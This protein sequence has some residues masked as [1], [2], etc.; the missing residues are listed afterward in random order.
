MSDVSGV[1]LGDARLAAKIQLLDARRHG[2]HLAIIP[3]LTVPTGSADAF[4]GDRGPVFSPALVG[5]RALGA[6]R[7]S[8]NAGYRVR[9][10]VTAMNLNVADELFMRV[11]AG[12]RFADAGGPPLG[13][14]LSVTGATAA[15]DPLA[16]FN[17]N[18]L[19]LL[20]GGTYQFTR[21]VSGLAG[22][23]M[24][25]EEGFGA[26]DWRVLIGLRIGQR[27]D[28]V[29]DGPAPIAMDTDGDGIVDN[30]D[31]CP[32]V[33]EDL[34]GFEDTDGCP[35]ADNDGDGVLDTADA[36]PNTAGVIENRGCPDADRDGDTV[37]DRLDN[38][39]DEPG[40]RENF[41]CAEAQLVQ[42][43]ADRI[44]ILD[45]VYFETDR[46]EIRRRSYGLLRNVA[47]V[48]RAHPEI[49]QIQVEG[50]TDSR[51]T[52][53]YNQHLSQRRAESVVQFLVDEG[54]DP[55]RLIGRG[56]GE[57][58]PVRTNSTSS[59]RAVNRRVEFN[60]T[61]ELPSA[62][63]LQ[64]LRVRSEVSVGRTARQRNR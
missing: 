56:F 38:C 12:Y 34:D 64:S 61:R 3:A 63:T 6:W 41:G 46:A 59:G 16:E 43:E 51:G 35:E 57:S 42:L 33:A 48:I 10:N 5:S 47:Q 22:A 49:A 50:H 17:Q 21:R 26:P 1:G 31:A 20:G 39:P 7:L 36:C 2:L 18:Y 29:S 44:R 9:E 11:G 52:D 55:A 58:R 25:L 30:D 54:V 14:N 23:G 28:G 15:A 62:P 27:T 13:L 24:G 4:R 45:A 40:P 37:V 8:V 32:R 19:E 60:I 53:E